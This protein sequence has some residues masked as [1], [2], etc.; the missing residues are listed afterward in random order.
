MKLDA[1]D[2]RSA[3]WLKLQAH[4]RTQ[5]DTLRR[6]NDGPLS[7]DETTYLRGRIAQCKAFLALSGEPGNGAP[8]DKAE[9]IDTYPTVDWETE[10]RP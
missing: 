7:P 3:L 10:E 6:R 1:I 5:L 9:A 2:K 4:W 8:T